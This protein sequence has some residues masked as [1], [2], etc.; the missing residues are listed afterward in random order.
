MA[1]ADGCLR[2]A[3]YLSAIGQLARQDDDRTVEIAMEITARSTDR[4]TSAEPESGEP[5]MKFIGIGWLV[6]VL[7]C[8]PAGDGH[9]AD[10]D[11]EI[12][13]PSS[14]ETAFERVIENY[15]EGLKALFL[16]VAD[17]LET[18]EL[19]TEMETNTFLQQQSKAIREQAFMI[20]NRDAAEIG[21]ENW[22]PQVAAEYWRKQGRSGQ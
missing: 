2:T 19:S 12:D 13:S 6:F 17:K 1:L 14:A 3:G 21:G 16:E 20:L 7:G 18:G 22:N 15:D 4:T 8:L 10:D 9:P 5:S 11:H